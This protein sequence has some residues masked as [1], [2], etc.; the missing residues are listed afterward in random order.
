MNSYIGLLIK[1]FY[2]ELFQSINFSA[3]NRILT[4]TRSRLLQKN[5]QNFILILL[6]MNKKLL[7]GLNVNILYEKS[8]TK[9][10]RRCLNDS[11]M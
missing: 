8:L 1:N 7:K 5:M 6:A 2:D 4:K 3:L 10:H 11:L 9:T